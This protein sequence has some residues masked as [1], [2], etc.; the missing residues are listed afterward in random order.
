MAGRVVDFR[1]ASLPTTHGENLVLRIL[2]RQKGIVPL[3]K[4]NLEES[5]LE[6]LK[7]M[8]A[9]PE[10][11][12]LVTG[13]TGSGKT[14]TLYSILNHINADA[15][16][17]MTL[18]DPV[19]YPMTMI[20]QTSV[21]EAA[22]L[23]FANGIRA[24]M[25]QDPDVILVGEIRD[26]ETAEMAFRAAMTGHQVYSTLHTNSAVGAFPR[27]LDIGIVPDILSGNI[28][29]ILAQRLVRRL[30]RTCRQSYDPD[31]KE[32]RLLG[33]AAA[34]SAA[35]FRAVGCEQC[36]YQGYKG[37][38]GILEILKI[39]AAIDELIARRATPR[40]ILTAA[41]ARGFRT[42]ADDGVRLVRAGTTSLDE[43]MRVVD[44]TDRMA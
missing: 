37:R 2:D 30:C 35:L 16:N 1:V 39:D 40:E 29:G 14:T 38:Q 10:G 33:L 15:L 43:V 34:E 24:M 20:R 26:Q 11:I 21:A 36:D 31:P 41:R 42:L 27:L 17:I 18:E 28:I 5:Q 6:L 23:D 22:K 9:R 3:D 44:L 7:L 8:I 4:L 13:P 32:R 25:R 19:E 12:I